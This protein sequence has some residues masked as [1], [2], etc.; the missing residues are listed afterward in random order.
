VAD[1]SFAGQV[2]AAMKKVRAITDDIGGV[3]TPEIKAAGRVLASA[4]RR[5]VSKAK[6]LRAGLKSRTLIG[7]PSKPGE[8]PHRVTGRLRRSVGTEA[9]GGVRRVG[10]A[11]FEARLL[12]DGVDQPGSGAT[13]GGQTYRDAAGRKRRTRGAQG[14]RKYQLE[15]RALMEP[16]T[17]K[18]LPKM[19][20]VYV[21]E[22]QRRVEGGRSSSGG[23][24]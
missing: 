14:K 10:F 9:V 22:V 15:P 8:A 4:F 3:N 20:D 18:A 13:P 7:D 11:A 21:G 23:V 1:F 5:Q 17:T 19:E 24:L 16:A 2:R 6:N 12:N